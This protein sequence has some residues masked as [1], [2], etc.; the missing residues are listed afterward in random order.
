MNV[1]KKKKRKKRYVIPI[2]DRPMTKKEELLFN[3]V[4]SEPSLKLEEYANVLGLSK[5]R[6]IKI[7][8]GLKTK[9][10][11]EAEMQPKRIFKIY[12]NKIKQ[13]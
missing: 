12:E 1:I 2:E 10:I 4:R 9:G 13:K 8:A 7:L 11:I 5:T 3:V 6:I